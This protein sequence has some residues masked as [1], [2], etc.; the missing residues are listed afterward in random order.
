MTHTLQQELEQAAAGVDVPGGDL[1]GVIRRARR[2]SRRRHQRATMV[3]G[4]FAAALAVAAVNA[5]RE[6]SSPTASAPSSEPGGPTLSP[7]LY[8]DRKPTRAGLLRYFE[9]PLPGVEQVD[10]VAV[11]K[12]TWGQVA[13]LMSRTFEL[14]SEPDMVAAVT[15]M[16][17]V[18]V[19]AGVLSSPADD[20]SV[21]KTRTYA[22]VVFAAEGGRP[23]LHSNRPGR[24]AWP[25]FFDELVD[26]GGE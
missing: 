17:Y 11:K 16:T 9:R 25:E 6:P 2:R 7:A 13:L 10:R 8:D 19:Q 22:V 21:E 4:I 12:A 20:P 3:V 5:S 15:E 24:E 23:L 26:E 1:E 14:G 18:V